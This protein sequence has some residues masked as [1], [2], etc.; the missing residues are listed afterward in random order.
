MTTIAIAPIGSS[1][2]WLGPAP[3]Y[4]RRPSSEESRQA[5]QSASGRV[6][7]RVPIDRMR[8]SKVDVHV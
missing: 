5:P 7:L 8:G 2:H 6:G 4:R 3:W 1:A